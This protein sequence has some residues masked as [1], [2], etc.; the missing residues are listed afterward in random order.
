MG[1]VNGKSIE[2]W[3]EPA[4]VAKSSTTQVQP[5]QMPLSIVEQPIIT[6]PGEIIPPVVKKK[7]I[8]V[9][10]QVQR[11]KL[12]EKKAKKFFASTLR[13][14][15]LVY[16]NSI[17]Q[18]NYLV[19]QFPDADEELYRADL[20]SI[21]GLAK[22]SS[23][24]PFD[25]TGNGSIDPEKVIF[26]QRWR[27][28]D[29]DE[30]LQTLAAFAKKFKFDCE[31]DLQ[32]RAQLLGVDGKK[33]FKMSSQKSND[34]IELPSLGKNKFRPFQKAGIA[35]A[36]ETKRCFIADEMGLGKTIQAIG[37]MA[38]VKQY[39]ALIVVPN[40][41]KFNWE[42]EC[43]K[44]LPKKKIVVLRNRYLPSLRREFSEKKKKKIIALG[45]KWLGL[46]DVVIVNYD[47][48]LKWLDYFKEMAPQVMV[49]DESH[50]VKGNS[51]RSRICK[52]LTDHVNP[53]YV[54]MLTGTPVMNRPVELVRQLQI[55]G[56]MAEFGGVSHFINRFCSIVNVD[57]SQLPPLP[58]P[59]PITG[60]MPE[61]TEEQKIGLQMKDELVRKYFQN[62]MEL[63]KQLRSTCYVRREK[64]DV[65]K[66]LPDK[67]R[68]T[69]EFEITNRDV[70]DRAKADICTY[71]ADMAV[72]DE[73]FL[74]SIKKLSAEEKIIRIKAY[75][76]EKSNKASRAQTLV[77]IEALK[78][79]A[80]FG[81]LAAIKEW[82]ENFFEENPKEKLVL[83]GVHKKMLSELEA[84]FAEYNPV[85]I[86]GGMSDK[87]RK[88]SEESFQKDP[89]VKLLI[90]SIDIAGVGLTFTAASNVAIV[91]LGWTP[92]KHD[93]A[94]DRCHRIGQK[95]AVTAYYLLAEDTIEMW[96]ADIIESK[97]QTVDATSYGDPL[98]KVR[99][100][101]S[102][103][104]DLIAKLAGKPLL[105]M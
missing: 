19:V 33:L 41:L 38:T 40:T 56:R 105:N 90:G 58:K 48:L 104:P 47:K 24:M 20:E 97:R 9:M 64:A 54:L 91:E 30:M 44:W 83:F 39:P 34:V 23:A 2:P 79:I 75:R 1:T 87:A 46:H 59:D 49:F 77:K 73:K 96:I 25:P 89:K 28:H 29:S 55:M 66:D 17:G 69:L 94:E 71:V 98:A 21:P 76:N 99:M 78:Q 93:Q 3:D 103:L 14:P 72:K 16:E 45:A 63:N 43:T 13:S 6:V 60:E 95:N 10:K 12:S 18:S 27:V 22:V 65:L 37:V 61:F 86:R 74:K 8:K 82:V 50:Y 92:A 32:I 26:V 42:R 31:G 101:G 36:L 5:V 102:I 88:H 80:A 53:E 68:T 52:E 100:M 11:R 15:K 35:Y 4:P 67:T 7:R 81:K 70:Y 51:V 84:A 85:S 62:Q 57:M